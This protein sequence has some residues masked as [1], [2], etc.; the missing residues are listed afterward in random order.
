[1]I[2][3]RYRMIKSLYIHDLGNISGTGRRIVFELVASS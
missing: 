2:A 3:G 1:M